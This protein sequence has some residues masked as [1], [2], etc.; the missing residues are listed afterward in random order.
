MENFYPS[1]CW[2]GNQPGRDLVPFPLEGIPVRAP[3]MRSPRFL[4]LF[5]P[6]PFEQGRRRMRNPIGG[7]LFLRALLHG[8]RE[9]S[10]SFRAC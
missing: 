5:L 2:I 6:L 4:I 1:Q 10:E 7:N 3:I 8:K 9:W